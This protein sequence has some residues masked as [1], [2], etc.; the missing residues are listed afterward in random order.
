MHHVN[1]VHHG[2]PAGLRQSGPIPT[3]APP[4]VSVSDA[5]AL[6]AGVGS[7]VVWYQRRKARQRKAEETRRREEQ[8]KATLFEL[9]DEALALLIRT[10]AAMLRMMA[11]RPCFAVGGHEACA[12]READTS[13]EVR[14]QAEIAVLIHDLAMLG[15]RFDSALPREDAA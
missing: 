6:L 10:Q 14:V 13:A 15:Q 9:R 3:I 7:L 12:A 5:L 4:P 2:V 11:G 8:R 1:L